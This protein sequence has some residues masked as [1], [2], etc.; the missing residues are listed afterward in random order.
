MESKITSLFTEI[1]KLLPFFLGLF[2]VQ[3]G[4]SL[5]SL[6]TEAFLSN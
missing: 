2:L 6:F 1:L 3:P 4:Q 5:N